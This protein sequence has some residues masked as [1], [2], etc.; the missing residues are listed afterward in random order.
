MGAREVE[1]V[2]NVLDEYTYYRQ[3]QAE[4]A[5]AYPGKIVTI[6]GNSVVDVHDDLGEAYVDALKEHDLGTFLLQHVC[7]EGN[8]QVPYISRFS[9]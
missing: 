1:P 2:T 9:R 4:L 3:H 8:E 7:E 6:K 5:R